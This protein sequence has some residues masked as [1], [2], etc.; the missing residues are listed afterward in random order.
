MDEETLAIVAAL[1]IT[2]AGEINSVSAGKGLSLS[3]VL[4]GF[5]TGTFLMII[6]AISPKIGRD[7]CFLAITAGGLVG[8]QKLFGALTSGNLGVGKQSTLNEQLNT[9]PSGLGSNGLVTGVPPLAPGVNASTLPY[10]EYE[11]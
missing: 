9:A 5:A 4:G 10:S 8:G 6:I 7:F 2:A 11:Q 3:N 1:T